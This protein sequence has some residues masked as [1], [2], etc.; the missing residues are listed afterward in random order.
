[1]TNNNNQLVTAKSSLLD[2]D[3]IFMGLEFGYF[4]CLFVVVIEMIFIQF[5]SA[6][7]CVLR[8]LSFHLESIYLADL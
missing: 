6:C 1:M 3:V 7:V 2:D 5:Y 4:V 8:S